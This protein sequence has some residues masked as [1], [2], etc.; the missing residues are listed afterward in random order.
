MPL[1][2]NGN[3]LFNST[4]IPPVSNPDFEN[5]L[6]IQ[7]LLN[8]MRILNRFGL[9]TIIV[10]GVIGNTVSGVVFAFSPLKNLSSSTVCIVHVTL[11]ISRF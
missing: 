5:S 3:V 2:T 10:I 11:N 7:T 4:D 1:A 6:Y 8:T 9:P